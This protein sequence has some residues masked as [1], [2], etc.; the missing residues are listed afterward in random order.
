MKKMKLN[1]KILVLLVLISLFVLSGCQRNVDANGITLAE[2]VIKLDTPWSA[3]LDESFFTAILVYPLAQV[4]NFIGKFSTPFFGVVITTILYNVLVLPLSIKSTAQTQKMQMLQPEMQKIQ[5]KYAGK[6]DER[7]RMMQAQELQAIYNKYNLNP[8]GSL[9][10]PF[11]QFPILIAMYYAVQRAD[12]VVNGTFAGIP[13]ATTPADAMKSIATGWPIV[14]IFVLMAISQLLSSKIPQWAAE[15]KRKKDKNYR[16]YKDT[17]APNSQAN[18]MIYVMVGMVVLIG[19][20]WPAAMSVYWL[21]NS[22]I[23]VVKTVFIQ[24]RYVDNA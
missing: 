1:K 17:A 10:M 6:D 3:M 14:V 23:N 12:I 2:K 13:L 11:L 8:L 22:V 5:E 21:I 19:L 4:V 18:M 24:W 15:F 9:I 16:A 20:R 7:S